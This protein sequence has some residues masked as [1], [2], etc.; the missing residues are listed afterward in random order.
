MKKSFKVGLGFGLAS[1]VI[2]TLGIM[3]GLESSTSSR[4]A[5]IG[6][7]ATIAIADAFSDAL[8]V[9]IA[10]ESEGNFSTVEIWQAT[11]ATLFSKMVFTST[12]LIPA[13]LLPLPIALLAAVIWGVIILL[14]QSFFLARSN[15]SKAWPIIAEHLLIA[16]VVITSAHYLGQMLAIFLG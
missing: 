14:A 4:L 2:T 3:I 6:G 12:F 8:G 16:A 15:K 13:I 10:K 9:H 5:V 11:L 7:I 1:S